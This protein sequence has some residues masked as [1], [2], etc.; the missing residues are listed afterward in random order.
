MAKRKTAKKTTKKQTSP[1]TP[2]SNPNQLPM[3]L[4]PRGPLELVHTAPERIRQIAH[5]SD[6]VLA[7]GEEKMT[8]AKEEAV[9]NRDRAREQA[10]KYQADA[11]KLLCEQADDY[12]EE[13]NATLCDNELCDVLQLPKSIRCTACGALPSRLHESKRWGKTQLTL[14]ISDPKAAGRPDTLLSRTIFVKSRT[15][16][17]KLLEQAGKAEKT[18][19]EF[20]AEAMDWQRKLAQMDRLSRLT[21]ANIAELELRGTEEGSAM[22][23]QLMEHLDENIAALK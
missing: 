11:Q 4:A 8:R 23:D 7:R 1:A 2:E 15:D 5:A 17:T 16:I 21:R 9:K 22:L 14:T 20:H 10:G 6:V 18:A 12:A 13:V 3:V 19:M